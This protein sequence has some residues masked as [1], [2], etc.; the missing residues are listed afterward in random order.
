MVGR[1]QMEESTGT[2]GL[3]SLLAKD[4][5]LLRRELL[6][7]LGVGEVDLRKVAEDDSREIQH[8]NQYITNAK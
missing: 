3:R 1:K 5:V 4:V 8:R 6:L 2:S 7:P